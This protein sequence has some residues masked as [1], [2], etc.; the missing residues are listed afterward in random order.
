[1]QGGI[2]ASRQVHREM[3][4]FAAFHGIKPMVV[5]YPMSLEG[6]NDAMKTLEEGKMRYRGVLSTEY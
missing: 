3:L 1:V 4:E 5:R 2:V 6:I